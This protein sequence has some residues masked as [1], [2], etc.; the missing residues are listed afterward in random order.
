MEQPLAPTPFRSPVQFLAF[1]FGSGLFPK[2]PGT[3]GTLVAVP[4]YLLVSGRGGHQAA[5]WGAK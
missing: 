3:A 5:G 1:G 2:P 4:L